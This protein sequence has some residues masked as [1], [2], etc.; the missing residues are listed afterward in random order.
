MFCFH[1]LHL[2]TVAVTVTCYTYTTYS[3]QHTA[4]SIH[5]ANNIHSIVTYITYTFFYSNIQHTY[6]HT[7]STVYCSHVSCISAY[8][9]YSTYKQTCYIV[10][11]LTTVITYYIHTLHTL[12][13]HCQLLHVT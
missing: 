10:L 7:Y 6:I 13:C 11:I 5:T 4:N 3:I 1:S 12:H 2:V 9:T 8:I